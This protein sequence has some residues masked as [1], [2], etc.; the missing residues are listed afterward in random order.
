MKKLQ[1]LWVQYGTPSNLKTLYI[2]LVLAAMVVAGG[3]PGGGS[4][5]GG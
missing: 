2:L 4:G 3:A 5:F 1:S